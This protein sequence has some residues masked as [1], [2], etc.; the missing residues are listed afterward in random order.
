V[1]VV[2]NKDKQMPKEV[3]AAISAI[4]KFLENTEK[5]FLTIEP[6]AKVCGANFSHP[7]RKGD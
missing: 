5:N 7:L 1:A 4:I 3:A 6:P 2:D